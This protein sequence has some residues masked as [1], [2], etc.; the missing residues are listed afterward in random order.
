MSNFFDEEKEHYHHHSSLDGTGSNPT[1]TRRTTT[2]TQHMSSSSGVRNRYYNE[3]NDDHMMKLI[4]LDRDETDQKLLLSP[5]LAAAPTASS[6]S[7]LSSRTTTAHPS[8]HKNFDI[9]KFDLTTTSTAGQTVSLSSATPLLSA[10]AAAATTAAP[11]VVSAAAVP[12]PATSTSFAHTKL[13]FPWKLQQL[14][15]DVDQSVQQQQASLSLQ[16]SVGPSPKW[17]DVVSWMPD[18]K[19]F[20]V[21]QP[22]VFAETIM[23]RY[24][25]MSKYTSF[26]R[27][28]YI[29]GFSKIEG[30]ICHGAFYHTKFVRG[31]R[32][33][34]FA[35]GRNQSGDRRLKTAVQR[36]IKT[37][38][39]LET[40]YSMHSHNQIGQQQQ[41]QQQQNSSIYQT[42]RRSSPVQGFRPNGE[43]RSSS[44]QPSPQ[45]SSSSLPSWQGGLP[46]VTMSSDVD[47]ATPS[48]SIDTVQHS[49]SQQQQN[50]PD[51]SM[52]EGWLEI[53][54]PRTIEEMLRG[55]FLS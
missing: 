25:K 48:Q 7:Q 20:R 45:M 24:F 35:I 11:L 51:R 18:G 31:D 4:V 30:G 49:A 12:T 13:P 23:R 42:Q 29:Y 21:H 36:R 10:V 22:D 19:A 9:N 46:S 40:D 44:S 38:L 28:L 55:P 14:L 2:G 26:T 8:F 27:Q 32:E 54:E 50:Q 6:S 37:Q 15:D 43:K 33:S 52:P 39:M 5:K 34:C 1:T 3:N 17:D 53:L 41:Q 16:G 47:Q